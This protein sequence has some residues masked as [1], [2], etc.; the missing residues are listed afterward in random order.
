MM[1][2]IIK[3]TESEKSEIIKSVEEALSKS[4]SFD[5][6]FTF[7][8][9]FDKIER[10][11]KILLSPTAFL[12]TQAL[13]AYSDKE[14]AWHGIA[15]RDNDETKDVYYIDDIIVYPQQVTSVT[16]ETDQVEY[17]TWLMNQEDNIF[18]NIRMQGHSHVNMGTSPSPTDL[19]YWSGI[20]EQ[21]EDDMFYIFMIWNKKG[22][23]TTK[24]YDFKKNILFETSDVSIGLNA[25]G[26][27]IDKFLSESKSMV[28]ERVSVSQYS[29]MYSSYPYFGG[30]G[31]YNSEKNKKN[32]DSKT[33]D[34]EEKKSEFEKNAKK[35]DEQPTKKKG[36]RK[37]DF[38]TGS[39]GKYNLTDY[40]SYDDYYDSY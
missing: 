38:Y 19:K 40:S 30:Y 36:K 17:Q 31:S 22:E 6:K 12:K 18:N 4:T 26:V 8:K 14:V 10:K 15:R 2:K 24:I 9:T 33:K 29:G 25:D 23:T 7:T 13:V 32:T 1:A 11:A 16:V 27:D 3:L 34:K 5:G 35:D 20:V 28:K 37:K 21:L 39:K